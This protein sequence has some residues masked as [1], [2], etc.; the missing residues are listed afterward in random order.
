M[1]HLAPYARKT[2]AVLGLGTS[3]L[4]SCKALLQARAQ[5]LAWDDNPR[6]R[7]L[8]KL[9]GVPIVD[10][11]ALNFENI[12][13]LLM[14]PGI[15]YDH[16]VA[17]NARR[18]G[19]PIIGDVKLLIDSAPHATY[20]G[21]TGTNGKSTTTALVAHMLKK[22]NIPCAV[23]GNL[24]VAIA[25]LP[26]LASG[27][28][29]VLEMSSYMLERNVNTRF[30]IGVFL[31]I[32][33]D[34]LARHKTME[35]YF[36]AKCLLFSRMGKDDTAIICIDDKYGKILSERHNP[37]AVKTVSYK[38][39]LQGTKYLKGIHNRQNIACA[40]AVGATFSLP[41]LAMERAV[42][43]F[44]GLPH[45]QQQVAVQDGI[46]FINDSKATNADAAAAALRLYKNIYW[47]VGGQEKS[48]Y[49][50]LI[51]HLS[52]I[53]RA[54]VIGEDTKN[55]LLFLK[56]HSIDTTVC[57]TLEKAVAGAYADANQK[58]TAHE[59][60]NI[61]ATI[62]LS[63]ACASWDQFNDFV[64]RGDTFIGCVQN[65]LTNSHKKSVT[66]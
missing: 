49:H 34:H 17:R 66:P 11:Y 33:P 27:A 1:L 48:D 10:L 60:G 3:G 9:Q 6:A 28:A 55:I 20:I 31:N 23:G 32:S 19:C 14:S 50:V 21:I 12:D 4:A 56:K 5:V 44:T 52:T 62:L 37:Y 53:K 26:T 57:H 61:P 38:D 16:V 47:I 24:G 25:T 46:T 45:R 43:S 51:P 42:A 15:G 65:I 59:S 29:Y 35:A 22:L 30:N 63:P 64:Q 13:Y 54:Y 2:L 58:H 40:F 41:K 36:R 7:T 39:V 8:A 18:Y